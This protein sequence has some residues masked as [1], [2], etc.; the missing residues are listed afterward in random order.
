MNAVTDV[1]P[2][3]QPPLISRVGLIGL[4]EVGTI[5]G[6][7]LSGLGLAR[8][9]GWDI[10]LRDARADAVRERAAAA[11]VAVCDG[12]A[13]LC[14]QADLLISAV[15]AANTLAAA[16][17]AAR[18]LRPGTWFLDLNS[19]S[20]GTKQQ[21]AAAIEAAGGRYVEAGVMTSVPPYGIRVPMLIGGPHAAGLQP[22]LQGWGMAVQVASDRV[23]IASATKMCRSILIKGLEALVI[24]S[25][26]AARH[27][28]VEEAMLATLRETFPGID[29]PR[30]GAYFFQR[31]AQ[32]GRRRAEEMREVARTV[33]EAGFEPV[34]ARAIAGKDD[35]MADHARDGHFAGVAPDASWQ[36]WADALLA[37]RRD[38]TTG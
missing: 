7:A 37:A 16:Q 2:A 5:F 13:A 9:G 32:H 12:M 22:A 6:R 3:T 24:E 14:A 20:P 36:A 11:G 33:A 19:A 34:M 27:Y 28:G 30:Q 18:H 4:G 29:W 26:T 1:S 10:A 35:W 38:R 17:E 25:Y 31:V 21:A 8:V 15:T 23:G